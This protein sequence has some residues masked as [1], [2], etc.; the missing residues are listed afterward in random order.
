MKIRK[1]AKDKTQQQKMA[2][3]Y[4]KVLTTLLQAVY[5]DVL[6]DEGVKS[7]KDITQEQ[8]RFYFDAVD[9]LRQIYLYGSHF[10]V[11]LTDFKQVQESTLQV[12]RSPGNSVLILGCGMLIVG[13]FLLFYI[14]HQR[15]WLVLYRDDAG[16]QQLLFAGSGN[17]NA[18]DFRAH[19][20]DLTERLDSLLKA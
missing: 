1:L 14:S 17:R 5:T 13:V 19:Y 7:E 10:Y 11:Q 8:E 2:D 3:A 18:A 15:L 4:N 16:K 6:K 20:H 9:A 12:T